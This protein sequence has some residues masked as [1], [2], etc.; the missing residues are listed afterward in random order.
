M[1][2]RSG[3][4]II[5]T[6][7]ER[8]EG[9]VK[10]S[11]QNRLRGSSDISAAVDSH[12]TI[13]KIKDEKD[14]LVIE[15]PKLRSEEEMSPFGISIIKNESGKIALVYSGDHSDYAERDANIKEIVLKLLNENK[16][17]ILIKDLV[18]NVQE[19][20]PL[21][22]KTIRKIINKLIQDEEIRYQKGNKNEKLCFISD[23]QENTSK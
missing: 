10:S 21:G 13:R 20:E 23:L 12:I 22:D 6:H 18:A 17:G 8:K 19:I 1:L 4:T 11:G 3:K 7:H 9:A 15:Q 16:E 2:F 14:K 5:L